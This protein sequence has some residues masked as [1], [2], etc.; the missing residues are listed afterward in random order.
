MRHASHIEV[1]GSPLLKYNNTNRN[2][3]IPYF[4]SKS[5]AFFF[6]FLF[7][8]KSNNTDISRDLV[9]C[10]FYLFVIDFLIFFL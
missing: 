4:F 2:T 5:T 3:R 9:I 8:E 1:F 6:S 10:N 7:L